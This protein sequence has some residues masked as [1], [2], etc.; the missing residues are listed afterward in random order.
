M[1]RNISTHQTQLQHNIKHK[2]THTHRGFARARVCV[3]QLSSTGKRK[4]ET[5]NR[6]IQDTVMEVYAV[7][8]PTTC[9]VQNVFDKL[10]KA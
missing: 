7:V 9:G 4:R 6:Q 5:V 10:S 3:V 1:S 8:P 2:R